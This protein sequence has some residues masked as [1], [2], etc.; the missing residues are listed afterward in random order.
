[1]VI[2]HP[3]FGSNLQISLNGRFAAYG[4]KVNL[5]YVSGKLVKNNDNTKVIP[6]QIGFQS[7]TSWILHFFLANYADGTA[8]AVGD[9]LNVFIPADN[10]APVAALTVVN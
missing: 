9:V 5:E 8:V 3:P 10:L 4:S 1:M 2:H 6:G 7:S